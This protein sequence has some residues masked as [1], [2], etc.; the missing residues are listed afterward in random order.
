MKNRVCDLC[1]SKINLKD[2]VSFDLYDLCNACIKLVRCAICRKCEGTTKVRIVDHE[3][4]EATCGENR[5][6]YKTITCD[7]CR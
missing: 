3:N 2:G 5:T 1:K 7:Q 6:Q 4:S